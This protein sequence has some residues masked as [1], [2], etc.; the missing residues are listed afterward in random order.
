M[1][2]VALGA[3]VLFSLIACSQKPSSPMAVVEAPG[4]RGGHT[5]DDSER[6][7]R[8][9]VGVGTGT[10]ASCSGSIYSESVVI[11]AAH[12]VAMQ[13]RDKGAP[14][15][16]FNIMFGKELRT[17][18]RVKTRKV[19]SYRIFPGYRHHDPEKGVFSVTQDFA[20]L[21]FDG[22]LPS[23]YE[24]I[25]ILEDS[26]ALVDGDRIAMAGFGSDCGY[27]GGYENI[28]RYF[29]SRYQ[30][31][32]S[33][34]DDAHSVK[35]LKDDLPGTYHVIEPK[36]GKD[37]C[38]GDSGGPQFVRHNG[39]W[40]QWGITVGHRHPSEGGLAKNGF[41]F[42]SDV[43]SKIE[44]IK[45][46]VASMEAERA[47][48][49]ELGS[50]LESYEKTLL[51]RSVVQIKNEKRERFC[52]G[53]LVSKSKV[54]TS[55]KCFPLG[56]DAHLTKVVFHDASTRE[57]IAIA[58]Y[59]NHDFIGDFKEL[60]VFH[61]DEDTSGND[62]VLLTFKG[63]LPLGFEPAKVDWSGEILPGARMITLGSAI[64]NFDYNPHNYAFRIAETTVLTADYSGLIL[65]DRWLSTAGFY[66]FGN[67]LF[68]YNGQEW[69]LVGI[70]TA[71]QGWASFYLDLSQQPMRFRE[72]IEE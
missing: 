64:S 17:G 8:H 12:C 11:T 10:W 18:E 26:S 40:K 32:T 36:D 52:N 46:A 70:S 66:N 28:L 23:G 60:D 35:M 19:V 45:S 30:R 68:K 47:Q 62:L 21:L 67:P 71:H 33:H 53:V 27:P 65:A 59:A 55:H 9:T 14:P 13:G 16:S 41:S 61:E 57:D 4:I 72:A 6:F 1:K 42:F 63:D 20:V 50:Y 51:A 22:G 37:V 49:Q 15:T 38:P 25:T 31:N 5:A 34:L 7:L 29:K 56:S 48:G 2:A 39:K 69:V 43:T 54:L 44:F 24:P 58:D 3:L